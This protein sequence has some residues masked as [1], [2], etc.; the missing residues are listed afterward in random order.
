MSVTTSKNFCPTHCFHYSGTTCPYCT[1]DK[2]AAYSRKFTKS[3]TPKKQE[4]KKQP[5][6]DVVTDDMLQAL[7]NHFNK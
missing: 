6:N 1:Q 7:I 3:E 2:I 4:T 5:E